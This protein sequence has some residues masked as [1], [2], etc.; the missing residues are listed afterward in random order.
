MVVW[1]VWLARGEWV[2]VGYLDLG[3]RRM[4]NRWVW[5]VGVEEEG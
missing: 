3:L 2:D 5:V 4:E 1:I